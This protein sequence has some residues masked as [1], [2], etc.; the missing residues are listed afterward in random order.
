MPSDPKA[1]AYSGVFFDQLSAGSL[2]TARITLK[3]LTSVV[4]IRSVVDIGCG[5]GPWLRAALEL[6]VERA[7]GVDGNHVDHGRLMIEP[8]LFRQCDL[9]VGGLAQT[10]SGERF[11]LAMCLEVAEHLS[12]DRADSFVA[13]LCSLSNLVLF[14]A[15]IPGQG[16]INHVNEQWPDYWA[17]LFQEHGCAC[18]D[19]MRPRLWYR[20]ECDWWYIQNTLVFARRNTV[21]FEDA[22]RFGAPVLDRP[23]RLVHPRMLAHYGFGRTQPT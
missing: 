17:A 23:M 3:E 22:S 10:L 6:G 14:S 21:A 18:F 12:A 19:V 1:T 9:G 5:I 13:E 4:P 11:D 2:A 7:I 16:G 15:A 8:K 20:Y